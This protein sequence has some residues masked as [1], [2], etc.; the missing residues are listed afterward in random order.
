MAGT[1][2]TIILDEPPEGPHSRWIKERAQYYQR[3]EPNIPESSV[4]T[5]SP[6]T[7]NGTYTMKLRGKESEE[8]WNAV[9]ES[10]PARVMHNLNVMA[11]D[12]D[13]WMQEL[14]RRWQS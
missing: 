9:Y 13:G 11:R 12:L 3:M 1:T 5:R 8:M 2:S 7:G 6:R 10:T 14:R 4:I